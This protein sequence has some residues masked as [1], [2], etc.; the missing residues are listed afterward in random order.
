MANHKSARKRARQ[1]LK[2]TKVNRS[3]LK[4]FRNN[5]SEYNSALDSKKT[6]EIQKIFS[7]INS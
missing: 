7:A 5:V 6:A 1:T 3:L 2:R 4:R